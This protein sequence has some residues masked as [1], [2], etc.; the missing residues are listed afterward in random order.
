MGTTLRQL[1]YDIGGGIPGGKKFKAIQTGGPSGG[2]LTEKDL[3]TPIDFGSLVAAGSM[4]GSGGAIVMDE[5]NCMVDVAKFYMTFI[6]DESCG[7]CSPCRI[8]T[9]RCLDILTKICDGKGEPQDLE[10]LKEL[11]NVIR[12]NSLCALGQTATNP[13][14]STI[15]AFPEEYEAHVVDHKCPAHVCKNMMEYYILPNKCI[16]CGLCMRNCPVGAI[17]PGTEPAHLPNGNV[18]PGKFAHVIDPKKCVKCGSCL[19]GCRIGAITKR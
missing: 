2:C 14:L 17:A 19:S 8:G 7:K 10:D 18:N 16:G 6:C 3:D 12:N 9:K 1:I 15:K 4:M 13:I 11:S 5:D